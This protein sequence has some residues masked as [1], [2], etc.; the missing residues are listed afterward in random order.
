VA[1]ANYPD[2]ALE[3]F[4]DSANEFETGKYKESLLSQARLLYQ[5]LLQTTNSE[6]VS[7]KF[8]GRLAKI[9]ATL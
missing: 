7:L 2:V 3:M 1:L 6:A 5:D 8:G 4:V 9:S